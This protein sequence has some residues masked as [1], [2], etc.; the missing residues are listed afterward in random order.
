MSLGPQH[1]VHADGEVS[2]LRRCTSAAYKAEHE[3]PHKQQTL[4]GHCVHLRSLCAAAIDN[5]PA[6]FGGLGSVELMEGGLVIRSLNSG[7]MPRKV[8]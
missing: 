4:R 3:Q 2:P 8:N 6:G 1:L 5:A 7:A